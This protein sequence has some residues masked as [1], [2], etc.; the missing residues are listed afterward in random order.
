[1]WSRSYLLSEHFFW[2]FVSI[3][4]Q[5]KE[6][7]F[8]KKKSRSCYDYWK[9]VKF[10][11]KNLCVKVIWEAETLIFQSSPGKFMSNV[12][13]NIW[14]NQRVFIICWLSSTLFCNCSSIWT[15]YCFEKWADQLQLSE[16]W[17]CVISARQ[18]IK[19]S[20]SSECANQ[21]IGAWTIRV[22]LLSE[23]KS[24]KGNLLWYQE[25]F[26]TASS[27]SRNKRF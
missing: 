27:T 16:K 20:Y 8:L 1:M 5:R 2:Q 17:E 11:M 21:P 13:P 23:L 25:I 19:Q 9:E 24:S 4:D 18:F 10:S 22:L 26:P 7:R 3:C 12:K 14:W 6:L 15:L